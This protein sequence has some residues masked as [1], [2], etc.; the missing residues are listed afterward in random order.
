VIATKRGRPRQ[1][2]DEQYRKIAEWKR[3]K[4]LAK[5]IGVPLRTAYMIRDGYTFKKVSP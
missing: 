5:D 1:V 3:L 2:T 4:D